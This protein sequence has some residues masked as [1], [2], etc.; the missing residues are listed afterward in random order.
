MRVS[1]VRF[2][3]RGFGWA[4]RL[5][6]AKLKTDKEDQGKV[7]LD[8]DSSAHLYPSCDSVEDSVDDLQKLTVISQR[9]GGVNRDLNT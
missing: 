3:K 5:G 6:S 9:Q 7:R 8:E 4:V 2:G 1:W